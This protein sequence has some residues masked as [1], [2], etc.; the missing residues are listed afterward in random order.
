M[1]IKNRFKEIK[2]LGDSIDQ[3]VLM[4]SPNGNYIVAGSFYSNELII[5]DSNSGKI[6]NKIV[7]DSNETHIFDLSKDSKCLALASSNLLL[8]FEINT[9]KKIA[10]LDGYNVEIMSVKFSPNGNFISSLGDNNI[11]KIWDYK[12]LLEICKFNSG[13][14][15]SGIA[16]LIYSPDEKYIL[17]TNKKINVWDLKEKKIIKQLEHFALSLD[18]SLD[19]KY[20]VSGSASYM[21]DEYIKVWNTNSWEE[22]RTISEEILVGGA[23]DM[24]MLVRLSPDNK[25]LIGCYTSVVKIFDF[26][27]GKLFK[28]FSLNSRTATL[29][30]DGKFIVYD[31]GNG[32]KM[33]EFDLD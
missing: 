29:S 14:T 16:E 30:P 24:T 15:G 2:T 3:S 7:S 26:N 5:L 20:L 1:N 22:I 17:E 32:I 13:T 33:F 23:P 11:I 12:S 18:I 21:D 25:Y 8:I 10:E 19:G 28:N 6:L 9:G 27:S 4:Y 31:D